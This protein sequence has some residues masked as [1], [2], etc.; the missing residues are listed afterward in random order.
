MCETESVPRNNSA[1]VSK[2]HEMHHITYR[3]TTESV[4]IHQPMNNLNTHS[5]IDC[6]ILSSF[7]RR[8]DSTTIVPSLNIKL[9]V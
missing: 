5:N 6:F 1:C 7:S 8:M 2:I 9:L 3:N 4:V